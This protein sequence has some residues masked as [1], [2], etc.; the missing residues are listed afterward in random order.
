[1]EAMSYLAL[2]IF[3]MNMFYM[4]RLQAHLWFL[5]QVWSN[6][7]KLFHELVWSWGRTKSDSFGQMDLML[8]GPGVC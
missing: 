1:M 5:W 3:D 4:S 8:I 7:Q 2:I 6:P